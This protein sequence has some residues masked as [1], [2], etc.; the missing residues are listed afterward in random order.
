M[1]IWEAVTWDVARAG[2]FTA[3]ALLTLA[4]VEGLALSLRWQTNRWPRIINAELH[5]FLTLLAVIFTGIH[6]LAVTIDP[7]TA[8]GLNEILV[9]LASH[10]RP[11][12]MAF[13]IVALYLGL[14][15]GLSTWLRPRIGYA[16][17][18]RLHVL[19]LVLYGLVTVHGI[20]TGTDTQTWWAVGIYAAS[21]VAVGIPLA[22][23]LAPQPPAPVKHPSNAGVPGTRPGPPPARTTYLPSRQA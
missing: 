23:R 10:Y 15:I 1:T 13:G 6:I 2:G 3:Y 9:P 12:W 18:R 14:A 7:Y 16:L 4:V 11:L 8:F 20:F 22:Y 17:W 21:L 19:T 5:N